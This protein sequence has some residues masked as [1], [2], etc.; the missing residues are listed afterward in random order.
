[1]KTHLYATGTGGLHAI[2]PEDGERSWKHDT[3]SWRWTAP[4]LGRDTLFVGGNKFY[5]FDPIPSFQIPGTGPAKRFE[6]SFHGRVG[7]G[8]VLNDGTLY[9]IAQTAERNYHLLALE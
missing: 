7:P 1:M 6:K 8:P 4:A 9:V 2:D 5:A 3:G